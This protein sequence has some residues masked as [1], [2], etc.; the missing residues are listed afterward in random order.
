M[1]RPLAIALAHAVLFVVWVWPLPSAGAPPFTAHMITHMAVV[2]VAAPLFAIGV[3][4][5]PLDPVRRWPGALAAIPL[6]MLELALV[7]AWHAPAL[8]AFARAGGLG[9]ALEQGS[10]LAAGFLLWMAAFGGDRETRRARAAGNVTGLL[11]TSMHMTLLGALLAL[12][13]R[14][15]Y[16]HAHGGALD[17]RVDQEIGGAIMLLAGGAAYLLGGLALGADVLFARVAPS[18]RVDRSGA[19]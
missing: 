4:G 1:R 5:G 7:W 10:F 8:H 14:A 19:P 17:P 2:V 9:V 18:L 15:L 12:A 11:L 13:P 3:A 6:S 16:D